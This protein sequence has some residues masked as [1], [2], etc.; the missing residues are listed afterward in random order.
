MRWKTEKLFNVAVIT[1]GQSPPGESYN[2]AGEGMPMFQGKA[3][4]REKYPV[5]VKWTTQPMRIAKEGDILISVRAPVGPTNIAPF[6]CCIGR[7]LAALRADGEK[8]DQSFLHYYLRYIEPK[9]SLRGQ[10]ST[11]AAIGRND[12]ET[13]PIPLPPLAEQRRIVE[14]LDQ[15]DAVRKLHREADAIAERILPA[16][17]YKM[18]GDPVRNEKGWKKE[19]LGK[20]IRVQGGFAFKS[21]DFQEKGILLVRIGN[22]KDERINVNG[23]AAYLPEHYLSEYS[24]YRLNVGDVLIALTGATTGK[25]ARYFGSDPPALLNQRVGLFQ[26]R[27]GSQIRLDYL[28][29]VM[30]SERAQNYIWQHARGFGQ[31]NI[32]PRQI[33]EYELPIPPV[34][35][36]TEFE[37]KCK[38]I[39]EITDEARESRKLLESTFSVLLHRAFTGEL[40][41]R[42]REEN[43]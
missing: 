32:A 37:L 23:D 15:A 14:I 19:I 24:E 21:D 41:K 27:E 20:H 22:L 34:E 43:V 18:F 1:M 28:Y 2:E 25:L 36:Q 4:F 3:E 17:F 8:L 42:W 5:P 31:P 10:G 13:L 9:F 11:F 40:T 12:L 16:L 26:R 7:G 30:K 38:E 6:E 39:L 29:Y 35:L 33:E